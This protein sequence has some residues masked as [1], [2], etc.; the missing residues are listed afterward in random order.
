VSPAALLLG[1]D[2]PLDPGRGN[3]LQL[4]GGITYQPT[5]E[6]KMQFNLV[7]ERLVRNDTGQTAFDVNILT[8]RGTYQ[9]TK[10]TFARAIIDYNTLSSRVRSQLLAG[11]TPSPDPIWSP[12]RRELDGLRCR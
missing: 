7:K 1:Q 8:M 10:A 4:K 9:F 2:A 12:T 11:W 6:L 3:L 5:N